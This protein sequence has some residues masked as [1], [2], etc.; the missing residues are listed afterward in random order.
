[1][2]K[3][4]KFS[5]KVVTER[6]IFPE[7][8]NATSP[9]LFSG[10]FVECQQAINSIRL[11]NRGFVGKKYV[12]WNFGHLW[13]TRVSHKKIKSSFGEMHSIFVWFSM[14]LKFE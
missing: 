6:I 13:D 12:Q 8:Y 5:M 3:K 4:D 7:W 11:Y 2:G 14:E 1:M 10:S 9:M